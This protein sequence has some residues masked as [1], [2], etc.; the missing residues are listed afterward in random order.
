[1]KVDE[2]AEQKYQNLVLLHMRALRLQQ[3]YTMLVA[4]IENVPEW[5]KA[6][7]EAGRRLGT[8]VRTGISGDGTLAWVTEDP[9]DD[10]ID[11]T[12]A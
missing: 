8:R 6:A 2:L 12:P 5:R 4:K 10:P 11:A 7:R 3:S 9:E 1:M